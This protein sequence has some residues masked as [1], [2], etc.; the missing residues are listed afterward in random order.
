M[1]SS[2]VVWNEKFTCNHCMI[3]YIKKLLLMLL[4]SNSTSLNCKCMCLFST[5]TTLLKNHKGYTNNMPLKKTKTKRNEN[6]F[7][8]MKAHKLDSFIFS[9]LK[10]YPLAI[11]G[12]DF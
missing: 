8:L 9:N 1:N 4:G 2:I 7:L 6:N 11:N 12:K 10:A 5:Y 3:A